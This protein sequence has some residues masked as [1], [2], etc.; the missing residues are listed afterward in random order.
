MR[1][2]VLIGLAILAGVAVPA[3]AQ[4]M[5]A[6]VRTWKGESWRL[7]QPSLEVFYTIRAPEKEEAGPATTLAISATPSEL[8]DVGVPEL[9]QLEAP[10]V[11]GAKQGHRQTN[12]V[13]LSRGGVETQIPLASIRSLQLFRKHPENDA[14]PPYVAAIHFRYSAA[15][16]LEDGSRIEGDYINLGTA[17]LRGMAPQGRVDIPWQEI[18]NVR[19]QPAAVAKTTEERVAPPPSLV[20][21]PKPRKPV[22]GESPLQDVF[23]DFDMSVLRGDTKAVLNQNVSWLRANPGAKV[24]VEGHCDARGTNE[25]NLALGERRAK[26]VRDYLVTAGIDPGRISIISYGEE[27]PFVPDHDESSW[28]WNRRGHFVVPE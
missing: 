21:A 9:P 26:A 18:E 8:Q 13:T 7:T 28:K 4:D 12:V 25:Y 1:F 11:V 20:E 5:I 23:F 17:V 2:N 24:I 16:V 22:E 27:R 19:F 15:A 3:A 14:L 6:E 10:T